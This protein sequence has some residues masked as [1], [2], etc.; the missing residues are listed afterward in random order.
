M[1][2]A[3]QATTIQVE[4]SRQKMSKESAIAAYD[5]AYDA[6]ANGAVMS[7]A[8]MK[9]ALRVLDLAWDDGRLTEIAR[10][11][12]VADH[13]ALTKEDFRKIATEVAY[14]KLFDT[15]GSGKL[16]DLQKLMMS[17]DAD[18]SGEFT[19]HE[20]QSIVHEL[21]AANRDKSRLA[22]ALALVVVLYVL[23][24][25]C[26]FGVALA[27]AEASKENHVQG[28]NLVALGGD[29]VRTDSVEARA[30]MW[31]LPLCD[32]VDLAYM[33]HVE[34]FFANGASDGADTPAVFKVAGAY[35]SAANAAA[36]VHLALADGGRLYIDA[37]ALVANFTDAASGAVYSVSFGDA[38]EARRRRRRL[39]ERAPRP[40]AA[41]TTPVGVIVSQ[42]EFNA[43]H[44]PD[45]DTSARRL[46]F[47]G[48]FGGALLT[49]GSFTM[50]AASG[51]F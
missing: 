36:H 28:D 11:E 25:V 8:A 3:V 42:E 5:A 40:T 33:K 43:A 47:G 27:A 41:P 45:E 15:D 20:V 19:V 37:D 7:R 2:P 17:Y 9:T 4:P 34:F 21:N 18:R 12:G 1:R 13:D 22:K 14:R 23:T 49:S 30:S 44:A 38:D 39:R 24:L 10:Q 35:K 26:I 6:N 16:D 51:G 48:T 46:Q 50:M 32:M 31:E 29:A